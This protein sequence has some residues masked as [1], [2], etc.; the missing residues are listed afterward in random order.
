[1]LK[2]FLIYV[3]GPIN[4]SAYMPKMFELAEK[5]LW[6]FVALVVAF[7]FKREIAFLL[8]RLQ[9]ATVGNNI[10]E[11]GRGSEEDRK[12]IEAL[13]ENAKRSSVGGRG[14][15]T[16]L[17][18]E[19]AALE[20]LS[21]QMAIAQLA[22]LLSKYQFVWSAWTT[23]QDYS[24][25][26][27]FSDQRAGGEIRY[28][29]KFTR[30]LYDFARQYR[31]KLPPELGQAFDELKVFISDIVPLQK[32]G[33]ELSGP[34]FSVSRYRDILQKLFTLLRATNT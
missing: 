30:D 11:F 34:Y 10:F 5:A 31:E 4:F 8:Q 26:V 16:A 2:K 24:H 22:F 15:I 27:R 12:K 7:L 23:S 28:I 29:D 6:P 3:I 25:A 14:E 19:P 9:K 21:P 17:P 18:I 32:Q 1:M 20:P 13:I 33:Q